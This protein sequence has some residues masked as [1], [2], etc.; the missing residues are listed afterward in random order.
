MLTPYSPADR[1]SRLLLS[2]MLV[3]LIVIADKCTAKNPFATLEGLLSSL[4]IHRA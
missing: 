4:D 1:I 3:P 2:D